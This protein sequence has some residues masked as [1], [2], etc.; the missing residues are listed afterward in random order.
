MVYC[1]GISWCPWLNDIGELD[2][3]ERAGV[4]SLIAIPLVAVPPVDM[5]PDLLGFVGNL[6]AVGLLPG[7]P[8]VLLFLHEILAILPVVVVALRFDQCTACQP[9]KGLDICIIEPRAAPVT[10][11]DAAL[12]VHIADVSLW[13]SGA[14]ALEVESLRPDRVLGGCALG[15][16]WS[17]RF[18]TMVVDVTRSRVSKAVSRP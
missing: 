17:S 6:V 14:F 3:A 2:H 11:C 9:F 8:S 1:I 7:E 5:L 4:R 16:L 15:G 13:G 12:E 10:L 18:C